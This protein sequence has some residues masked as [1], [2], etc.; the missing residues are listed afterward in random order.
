MPDHARRA[1]VIVDRDSR[2]LKS[3]KIIKLI[4]E[5]KFSAAHNLLEVGCGSG[6]ISS[7]FAVAGQGQLNVCAVDVMDNRLEKDGYDFQLVDGTTLPY[8]DKSFDLV[9]T[10]HVIEHVGDRST[11]LHHLQ[12]ITRVLKTDG[13][14]YLAVPNRWRIF[15]PHYRLPLLSWLPQWSSD[16]Y[17]RLSR[18]GS[19]YDC[20]P[21][22]S[23]DA[24]ALFQDANMQIQNATLDAL[25]AT[26][27]IEHH[28]Q[29]LAR[30][31]N[32]LLPDWMLSII[33]PI[34]PTF[35]FLLRPRQP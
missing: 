8:P 9:V 5:Q 33:M 25:R 24:I 7:A 4:G 32:S 10:N 13:L 27:S 20:Q 16:I 21:L 22:G 30:L 18:R 34:I 11:Q 23:R 17:V 12:E 19:Y 29:P 26:L 6:V 2:L 31:A 28:S 14:I 3:A 15:E 1:H 35:V